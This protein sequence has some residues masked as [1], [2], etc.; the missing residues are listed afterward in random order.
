[1]SVTSM[2][3]VS[4]LRRQI[5]IKLENILIL[6]IF[7]LCAKK[8]ILK[9]KDYFIFIFNYLFNNYKNMY[10]FYIS[11]KGFHLNRLKKKAVIYFWLFPL[12]INKKFLSLLKKTVFY[13]FSIMIKIFNIIILKGFSKNKKKIKKN[14]T[15][16]QYY[17]FFACEL[18][19]LPLMLLMRKYG[20]KIGW[21]KSKKASRCLDENITHYIVNSE[22]TE[23]ILDNRYI[24]VSKFIKLLSSI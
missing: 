12:C 7:Y 6:L 18:P 8:K 21:K 3:P 13:F 19:I 9:K 2:R 24:S 16:Y 10:H 14:K 5:I 11:S 23:K 17:F 1:M 22:K 20:C 15:L 4:Y